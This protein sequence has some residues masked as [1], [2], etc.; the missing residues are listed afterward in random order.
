MGAPSVFWG[1]KKCL[2]QLTP[3]E[4]ATLETFVRTGLRGPQAILRARLLLLA[5]EQ[6]NARNDA[7]IAKTLN[8]NLHTVEQNRKRYAQD[9]LQ[10]VPNRR[11]RMDK[12]IPAKVDGQVEAQR[13]RLACSQTPHDE[14]SWTLAM[15]GDALVQLGVVDSS[16]RKAVRKTLK[17]TVPS[18]N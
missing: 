17:K 15:S 4:R 2:V 6:G 1:T 14:P 12:G 8:L 5:D 16:S 18:R 11:P 3:D 10:A 7:D 9:S 13:T